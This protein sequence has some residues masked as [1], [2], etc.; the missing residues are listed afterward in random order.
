MKCV[1]DFWT[2][3]V[4]TPKKWLLGSTDMELDQ[5]NNNQS[6]EII[7]LVA[8]DL[9]TNPNNLSVL[10]EQLTPE[11]KEI[12]SDLLKKEGS[13]TENTYA[14]VNSNGFLL[15]L[16]L[17]IHIFEK[18]DG[19]TLQ[20]ICKVCKFWYKVI[21]KNEVLWQNMFLKRW[22]I[23]G[24]LIEHSLQPNWKNLYIMCHKKW[25]VI[26]KIKMPDLSGYPESVRKFLREIHSGA[27]PDKLGHYTHV[28]TFA[29][30]IWY[31]F[32]PQ[33]HKWKWTPDRVNWM[34]CPE[35]VVNGGFWHGQRPV[36]A[37]LQVIRYLHDI[38]PVPGLLED[39]LKIYKKG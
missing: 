21:D 10:L 31:E 23:E 32:D 6:T 22:I 27:L 29:T 34:I 12:L 28:A 37:N 33:M 11:T 18:L 24:K 19:V 16:E 9:N 8:S 17:M 2:N 14:T 5:N 1:M 15:P 25:E 4:Y 20:R 39:N 36:N 38:C 35:T 7:N 13:V 26:D 3:V 30:P